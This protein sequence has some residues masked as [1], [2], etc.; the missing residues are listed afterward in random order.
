[1]AGGQ[2]RGVERRETALLHDDPPVDDAPSHPLRRAEG[3]GRHGIVQGARHPDAAQ[4]EGDHVR[5]HARGQRADVVPVQHLRA[6]QRRNLQGLPGGHRR[7]PVAD[8]GEQHG[9]PGLAEEVGAVVG[10]RPVDPQAHRHALAAHLPDRRDPGGEAHVRAGAVGDPRTRA[11]EQG[12]PRRVE[13]HAVGVPDVRTGPAEVGGIVRRAHAELFQA[14]ADVVVVLGEMGVQADPIAPGEVRRIPHQA[15]AHGEGRAGRHH[16][17]AHGEP[18]RVVPALDQGLH[19]LQDR[20]FVLHHRIRGQ[21]ARALA[22]AH[23][24]PCGVEAHPDLGG[25][26]EGI[27]QPAAVRIDVEVV[28]RRGAA[29]EDQ[30]GH[31]GLGGD[32]DHLRRQAGPERV[33]GLQPAE[34]VGILRRGHR[35]GQGL[36]HVVVGVHE[37][38]QHR[39]AAHVQH[40]IGLHRQV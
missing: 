36:E 4:V 11:A 20:P 3:Q 16:D 8:P 14:V 23:G 22:D 39:V 31:G 19:V 35:P 26:L 27:L 25:A 17:P 10:G 9:L 24:A 6:A 40:R 21:A 2:R 38:G 33:E 7:R 1:V 37:A 28:A 34:Q 15:P 12:D 5:R 18:G 32:A 30:L 13:L 29:G